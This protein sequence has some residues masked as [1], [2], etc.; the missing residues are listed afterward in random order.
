MATPLPNKNTDA[1]R[2]VDFML[3]C[4]GNC[5]KDGKWKLLSV[6]VSISVCVCVCMCM[7]VY[8]YVFMC[9]Y[10]YVW[11]VFMMLW[12]MMWCLLSGVTAGRCSLPVFRCSSVVQRPVFHDGFSG[13]EYPQRAFHNN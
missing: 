6:Y 12:M 2:Q 13:W 4:G 3:C 9:K 5:Q 10:V 11:Y 7:Y 8:V 1:R